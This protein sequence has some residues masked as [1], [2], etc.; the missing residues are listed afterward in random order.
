M[1]LEQTKVLAILLRKAHKN[2]EEI[3]GMPLVLHPQIYQQMGLSREEDWQK[4]PE[5]KHR[6]FGGWNSLVSSPSSRLHS[7]GV[8]HE[9]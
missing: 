3:Q 4:K 7:C 6:E 8:P 2:H 5:R 9:K 1:S